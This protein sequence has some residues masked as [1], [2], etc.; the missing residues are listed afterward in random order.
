MQKKNTQQNI[1]EEFLDYVNNF[2]KK[3]AQTGQ[4]FYAFEKFVKIYAEKQDVNIDLLL[5]EITNLI[6]LFEKRNERLTPELRE[7]ITNQ[8]K[9][10]FVSDITL[11][12]IFNNW[13][14]TNVFEKKEIEKK[15]KKEKVEFIFPHERR[16]KRIKRTVLGGIGVAIVGFIFWI[17]SVATVEPWKNQEITKTKIQTK[18]KQQDDETLIAAES[19]DIDKK[20]ELEKELEKQRQEIEFLKKKIEKETQSKKELIAQ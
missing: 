6:V 16:Q 18:N 13:E 2:V 12:T 1:S 20:R 5:K 3:V 4:G 10:C 17:I 11:Q 19:K 9:K 14:Q 7:N 15:P 8:A